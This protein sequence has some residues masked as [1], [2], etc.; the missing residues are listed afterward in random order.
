[1]YLEKDKEYYYEA[2]FA[3]YLGEYMFELGLFA[4]RTNFT[5]T[6]LPDLVRDEQQHIVLKS[7][8][9]P[10][11]YTHLTLPTICSV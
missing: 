6:Y 2:Y 9:Q 4:G 7:N 5:Q 3:D 11:S 8:A 10:V 1:M